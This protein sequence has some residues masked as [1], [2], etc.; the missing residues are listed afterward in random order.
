LASLAPWRFVYFLGSSFRLS[1]TS[2]STVSVN[3]P[4]P[5]S[6]GKELAGLKVWYAALGKEFDPLAP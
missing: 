1:S 2:R 5:C 4:S 3:S 6:V